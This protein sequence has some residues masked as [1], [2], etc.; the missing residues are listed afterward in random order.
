MIELL[1]VVLAFGVGVLLTLLLTRQFYNNQVAANALKHER[2][3]KQLE[4]RLREAHGQ[5]TVLCK[6]SHPI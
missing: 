6:C 2:E 3:V 1:P 4:E 5:R